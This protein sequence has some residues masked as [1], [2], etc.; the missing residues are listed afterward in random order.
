MSFLEQVLIC[1]FGIT[2]FSRPSR[3]GSW[4]WGCGTKMIVSFSNADSSSAH[5]FSRTKAIIFLDLLISHSG[6]TN[7]LCKFICVWIHPV[8]VCEGICALHLVSCVSYRLF[9]GVTTA[10]VLQREKTPRW[11]WAGLPIMCYCRNVHKL[12]LFVKLYS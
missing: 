11:L 7:N 9:D 1:E 12:E 3:T 10:T 6:L 5:E 2:S 4:T 8:Y